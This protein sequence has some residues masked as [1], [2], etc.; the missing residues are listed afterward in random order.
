MPNEFWLG[1][2]VVLEPVA[3]ALSHG[4]KAYILS[5]WPQ[6]FDG[7]PQVNGVRAAEQL[8][9]GCVTIDLTEAIRSVEKK[10]DERV[11]MPGKLRRIYDAA[12]V[13]PSAI[14]PPKLYLTSAEV[15][16]LRKYSQLFP[17]PRVGV[18]LKS[19]V[20]LKCWAYTYL[21]LKSL[22]KKR[23][24][25][26]VFTDDLENGENRK[27][28][29]G[30]H[31]VVGRDIRT[32][33]IFVAMM[34]VLAGPDTGLMHIGG[35]LGTPL[36]VVGYEFFQDLYEPYERAIYLGSNRFSREQGITG[37][38]AG[39][40]LKAVDS[41]LMVPRAQYTCGD[42]P[43]VMTALR[44]LFIRF[45]GV[46]DVILSLVAIATARSLDGL[47]HYT[48]VT[49]PGLG[50]LVRASG[51]CDEVIEIEYK[52]ATDGRPSPPPG[53]DLDGYDVIHNLINAVDF[54]ESSAY[55]PRAELF[56]R[57]IGLAS[58]DYESAWRPQI[59]DEWR[60]SA[61]AILAGMGVDAS[62]R[63][64]VMQVDS[65]GHSRRWPKP[66]QKEFCGL[67]S[68]H[69]YCVVLVSDLRAK[70]YPRSAVN[71][72]GETTLTE[73]VGLVA[74][75]DM[76]VAPDSA[77]VHIAG[78]LGKQCVALFGSVDPGLRVAH[79]DSVHPIVGKAK[80][81]PCN[82]WMRASCGT[83][84]KAMKCMWSIR[85]RDVLKRVEE[86]SKQGGTDYDRKQS[87]RQVRRGTERADR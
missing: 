3:R 57:E 51:V 17:G 84:K 48:Y 38:S 9:E 26:F 25:V 68:K 50:D 14:T 5:R 79:Y 45:R 75:S 43:E 65:K 42:K 29:P 70:G 82:D 85:S 23:Y 77:L 55:V 1:D 64:L 19:R 63:L 11:V 52:H 27:L 39:S 58:V 60:E 18:V 24:N 41:S 49:S 36:V 86:V 73:L 69:G 7:H 16:D 83:G 30:V 33:M 81:T 56:A 10:G 34:D 21:L 35:A 78:W 54:Q 61:R 2:S 28:P 46:G 72:T 40:V 53:L 59:P 4:Q 22:I 12:G 67:A 47:S 76:V 20:A 87:P 71:L 62:R 8:P 32:A 37:I 15:A 74:L 13:P 80:C 44:E 6:L 31:T 66:R